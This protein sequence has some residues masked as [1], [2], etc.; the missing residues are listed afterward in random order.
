MKSGIENLS[1]YSLDDIKVHYGLDKPTQ[2]QALAYTQGTDIHVAPGQEQHLPNEAWHVVQ[3]KQGRVQPT[4]Q[5]QGANINDDGEL[6]RE[7]DNKGNHSQTAQ[8]HYSLMQNIDNVIIQKRAARITNVPAPIIMNH[9]TKIE[10]EGFDPQRK[11]LAE[12][13]PSEDSKKPSE[14]SWFAPD[15]KFSIHAAARLVVEDLLKSGNPQNIYV[16]KY[17]SSDILNLCEWQIWYH[18]PEDIGY[19]GDS[20]ANERKVYTSLFALKILKDKKKSLQMKERSKI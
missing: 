2:L 12:F 5:M 17:Q 3:Q 14:P 6:E 16:H 10:T 11:I 9:G 18:V 8:R 1:G 20:T 19:K 7:A 4:I 13:E 15:I